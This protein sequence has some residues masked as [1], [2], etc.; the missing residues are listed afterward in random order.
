MESEQ[1]CEA[2]CR[3]LATLHTLGLQIVVIHGGGKEISRLLERLSIPSQF[4][5]GL[6]VTSREAMVATEMVLSGATN[7]RLVSYINRFGAT[8]VGVSG[9]DG[10]LLE[11]RVLRG[12]GGEDLG[13]T[14]EVSRCD[15]TLLTT[16]LQAG[17]LPVI[18]PV[19]E[20]PSGE[21]LNLNADYAAA[22]ISGALRAEKSIFLT[23]VDGVRAHSAVQA[24]LSAAQ[25]QQLIDSGEISGGMIPKVTC[26]LRAVAS[27]A[28]EAVICN[29]GQ[30]YSISRALLGMPN[31]GTRI[32]A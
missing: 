23:D 24:E 7:K 27:G 22:A 6:R 32:T 11:A 26:A 16:L 15:P 12:P 18:S 21:A 30:P 5:G 1:V 28:H 9:R 31:S 19:G 4:I 2:V 3:E 13:H 29:A 8:A 25:I 14:G 20:I 17:M 10:R